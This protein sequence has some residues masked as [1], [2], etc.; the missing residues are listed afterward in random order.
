MIEREL[1]REMQ[2]AVDTSTNYAGIAL[3]EEGRVFAEM[4]WRCGQNHTVQLLPALSFLLQQQTMDVK[5]ATGLVVARGPGSYNGLRVGLSTVKGLSFSLDV[6]LVGV[7]TLEAEAYA[8]AD[9][10]L[11]VCP[12]FNAGRGEVAAAVYQKLGGAWKRLLPERVTTVEELCST[13]AE[14]T[15]FCGEYVPV[16]ASRVT[17]LLGDKAVFVSPGA[18]LR[19]AGYLVELGYMRLKAKDYDDPATLQPLYLRAPAI[20]EP[21]RR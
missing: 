17:E 3:A 11:G 18:A 2:I 15:L 10:G 14:P 1:V 9:R 21:K 16:I 19:R 20:T 13:I 8:H 6:P 12:V 5:S 4:N 7:S